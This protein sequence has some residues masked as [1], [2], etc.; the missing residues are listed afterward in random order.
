MIYHVYRG[1]KR[2]GAWCVNTPLFFNVQFNL[3]M[4]GEV[5]Y[6]L[7]M[8]DLETNCVVLTPVPVYK[9]HAL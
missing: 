2:S 5:E 4:R 3:F 6:L 1:V 9:K 7:T 8:A